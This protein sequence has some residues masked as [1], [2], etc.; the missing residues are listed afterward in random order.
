MSRNL[1]RPPYEVRVGDLVCGVY[2]D[3][4]L[5]APLRMHALGVPEE[6]LRRVMNAHGHSSDMVETPIC[7]LLIKT[8][9]PDLFRRGVR[10]PERTAPDA[11]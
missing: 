6:E 3:G 5:I 4:H 11:A 8:A 9:T 7:V 1:L 10:R 2:S